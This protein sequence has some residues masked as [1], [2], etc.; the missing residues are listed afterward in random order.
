MF[1]YVVQC[2]KPE[3]PQ[4]T[5]TEY[6][7]FELE[8]LALAFEHSL[9]PGEFDL[10]KGTLT[11]LAPWVFSLNHIHYAPQMSVHMRDMCGLNNIH[12][13]VAQEFS[14]GKFFVVKS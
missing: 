8:L 1:Q 10:Y 11:K 4:S 6:I 13:G 7:G 14:L 5:S 2:G 9:Y 3:S 12:P